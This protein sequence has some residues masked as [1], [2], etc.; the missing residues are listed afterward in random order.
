MKMS[1]QP[2][3]ITT[4][5]GLRER[6]DPTPDCQRPPAWTL[7][8]KQLL[9]DTILRGYD[10]PKMYWQRLP[11]GEAFEFGVIDGQQ[12]LTSFIAFLVAAKHCPDSTQ[13]QPFATKLSPI[14][15]L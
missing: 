3:P 1:K 12:R 2:Y 15:F 14:F 7:K 10:I 11:K 5:C 6:I 8:Q 4:L 13:K 9:I